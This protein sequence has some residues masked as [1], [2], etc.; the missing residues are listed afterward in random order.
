ML[1]TSLT[2]IV[3]VAIIVVAVN[4][5]KYKMANIK[6]CYDS[7]KLVVRWSVN[8]S[9]VNS[10]RNTRTFNSELTTYRFVIG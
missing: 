2:A 10:S 8:R 5:M 9:Y 3:V 6:T 1:Q 4:V 7:W